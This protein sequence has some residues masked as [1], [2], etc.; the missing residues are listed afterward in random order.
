M[1]MLV[2]GS[3]STWSNVTSGVPKRS[4]LGPALFV[5]YINYV[6]KIIQLSIRLHDDATIVYR[7]IKSFDD[8]NILQDD[9]DTLSE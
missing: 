7:E 5:L 2:N 3:H 1:L 8:H 4:I 9:L 6:R